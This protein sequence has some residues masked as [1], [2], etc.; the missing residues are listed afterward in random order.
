MG[1]IGNLASSKYLIEMILNHKNE[2][3]KLQAANALGNITSRFE[4][5]L[6]S[7]ITVLAE[8]SGDYYIFIYALKEYLNFKLVTSAN[9]QV[10][11]RLTEWLFKRSETTFEGE[12][13]YQLIA[14][15]VGKIAFLSINQIPL[16]VKFAQ[17]QVE[18][19]RFVLANSL[20]F[21]FDRKSKE[22]IQEENL[23]NYL[24]TTSTFFIK[25]KCL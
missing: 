3:F 10:D 6:L 21:Y 24:S 9:A 13:I 11:S 16:I 19:H 7:E 20:R 1:Y 4:S 8:K 15:C 25:L 23:E 17:S 22:S 5:D 2:E 12:S 14:E 18:N